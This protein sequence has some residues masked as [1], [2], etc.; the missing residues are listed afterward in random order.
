MLGSC[1]RDMTL[2]FSWLGPTV[3]SGYRSERLVGMKGL[4]ARTSN[5]GFRQ[6]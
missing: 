5:R 6:S 1:K 2:I 4:Y 3:G